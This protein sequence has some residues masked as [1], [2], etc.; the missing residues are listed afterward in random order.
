MVECRKHI[1]RTC[2]VA[3]TEY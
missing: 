2:A 1:M 3:L